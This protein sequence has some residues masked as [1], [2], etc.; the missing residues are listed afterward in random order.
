[1]KKATITEIAT[2]TNILNVQLTFEG[3]MH[4]H[5]HNNGET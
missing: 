2:V 1:M 5:G 4:S 3:I